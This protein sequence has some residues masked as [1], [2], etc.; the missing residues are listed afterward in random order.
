MKTFAVALVLAACAPA[1]APT[2]RYVLRRCPS[3]QASLGDFTVTALMLAKSALAIN[4]GHEARAYTYAGI[5]MSVA[6]A[7]NFSECPRVP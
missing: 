5:G 7:S 4:A 2:Q 6:L 1:C 3:M